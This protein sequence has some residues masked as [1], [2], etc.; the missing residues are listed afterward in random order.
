MNVSSGVLKPS[1]SW[2]L[3][4]ELPSFSQKG[5]GGAWIKVECL[6]ANSWFLPECDSD[7]GDGRSLRLH[8]CATP[9][10][11]CSCT[12]GHKERGFH[13]E[14]WRRITRENVTQGD[15]SWNLP[16]TELKDL[17]TFVDD[18]RRRT[19]GTVR[20][21]ERQP[22]AQDKGSGKLAL[23][24]VNFRKPSRRSN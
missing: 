21:R 15:L 2:I 5:P 7:G 19:A 13:S 3:T 18:F 12:D 4:G 24:T 23:Q 20:K 8:L 6:A 14:S 1:V 11:T 17:G 22:H 9:L 16:E 10:E